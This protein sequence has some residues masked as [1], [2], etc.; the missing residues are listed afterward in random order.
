MLTLKSMLR[1]ASSE[2]SNTA[3]FGACALR[4]RCGLRGHNATRLPLS[5]CNAGAKLHLN[6]QSLLSKSSKQQPPRRLFFPRTKRQQEYAD[7]LESPICPGGDNNL[8]EKSGIV[9]GELVRSRDNPDVVVVTGPAGTSKTLGAVLV[10]L[11][12]L[13]HGEV[14]KLVLTRPAVSADEDLGFLPGTLEDKMRVWLLPV[15]DSF[16]VVLRRDEIERLMTSK[17]IEVCSL[18]HMRGRTFRNSYVVVDECQNTTPSQMLMLLTRIGEGSR[19]VFTG[20]PGQH[21]RGGHESASGLCDFVSRYYLQHAAKTVMGINEDN[22]G[23]IKLFQFDRDDV[24]RH[25]VIPQ[26]LDMYGDM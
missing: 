23:C 24:Q 25:P 12:K 3:R 7:L 18:S 2:A 6:T 17:A 8:A 1:L 15:M 19:F 4:S 20:D 9:A 14:D 26:V 13:I 10:G 11:Q 5:S 16:S 21:D 22:S